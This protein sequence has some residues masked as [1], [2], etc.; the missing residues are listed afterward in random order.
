MY[1]GRT[2]VFQGR[3]KVALV[4]SLSRRHNCFFVL[5]WSAGVCRAPCGYS[6]QIWR[7]ELARLLVCG[8]THS[9]DGFVCSAQFLV[10]TLK[11]SLFVFNTTVLG[12]CNM[13]I[14]RR[15][16]AYKQICMMELLHGISGLIHRQR[17]STEVYPYR[18]K[19]VCLDT[20]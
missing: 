17:K 8:R 4:P 9:T 6:R 2:Y 14:H 11:L 1:I 10:F 5:I 19:C 20:R 3:E 13:N 18:K 12:T 15:H 16:H 7:A